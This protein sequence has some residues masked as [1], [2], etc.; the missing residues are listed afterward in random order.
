MENSVLNLLQDRLATRS[1]DV[2]PLPDPA[3]KQLMEAVRLTPSCFNNQPWRYLFLESEKSRSLGV[4]ALSAGNRPWASRAPLLILGYSRKEN[5][6][7]LPGRVYHQFDLGMSAMNLM[8]AATY[9]G[10]VARPMAGFDPQKA[11][12]LFSLSD[13]DEPLIMIAVGHPSK[14]ETHLPDHYIGIGTKPR[15]RKAAADTI[16]RR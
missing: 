12:E 16:E 7:V 3:V 5:D 14:D 8:L 13:Q 11:R 4:E 2:R 15:E 10:L 9:L 6:C 1:I